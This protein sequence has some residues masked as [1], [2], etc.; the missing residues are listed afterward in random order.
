MNRLNY[1]VIAIIL[2][3][4]QVSI[5]YAEPVGTT[6]AY[7]GYLSETGNPANDIVDFLFMLYNDESG[8]TQVGPTVD[9]NN[10]NVTDGE[11][12][13]QID[14][15]SNVF[16]GDARWLVS[17]VQGSGDDRFTRLTP[18]QKIMPTPYSIY[19]QKAGEVI[20]GIGIQGTGTANYIPK[21]TDTDSINNSIIYESSGSIG[22]GTTDPTATLHVNG[23]LALQN[24]AVID[25]IST[26][27]TLADN[28]DS[29]VP[30]EQAVKTYV[31]SQIPAEG[32]GTVPIGG[33]VAWLKLF[34]G[35][36]ALP[37]NFKECDGLILSDIDSPYDGQTLPD[38]NGNSGTQRFLR[39]STTSGAT[40]GSETHA[41]SISM[42]KAQTDPYS[43]SATNGVPSTGVTSTLPSYYEVVWIMRVK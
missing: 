40:G 17:E 23:S 35:T 22:I 5:S 6:F 21:F 24:G 41:H 38:L 36:P 33:I 32:V 14:F 12:N 16:N 11:F 39:G 43:G 18:R 13:V 8:G 29:A 10:V 25:E 20:G 31:N 27:G 2:L 30:T 19:A 4:A 15:G 28:S 42:N 34:P 37:D 1:F 26:D 9:A 7:E 3:V